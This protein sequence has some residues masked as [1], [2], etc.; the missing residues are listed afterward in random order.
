MNAVK[1]PHA[2]VVHVGNYLKPGCDGAAASLRG[3]VCALHS[4]GVDVSVWQFEVALQQVTSS[5]SDTGL[6]VHRIPRFHNPLLAAVAVPAVSRSWI[7][8]RLSE[9]DFLHLH[10]V[11]TPQNIFS[12]R[13]G[14][15]Y[16]VTPQG[17]WSKHVLRGHRAI[18]KS[19]WIAMFERSLWTNA[20]FVQAV[21]VTECRD[22]RELPRVSR[23]TFIPNGV[24]L[25][26]VFPRDTCRKPYFLFVGRLAVEQKGLD[27]LV[28]AYAAA[29]R[30][31]EHIPDLIIAG[32]DFRDGSVRLRRQISALGLADKIRL[33][34]PVSGETKNSLLRNALVFVH[35]SRWEGMPLSILEALAHATPCIVT[36]P[37]GLGEWVAQNNCGWRV[38]VSVEAIA[39]KL[40]TAA[41]QRSEVEERSLNSRRAVGKDFAW[42]NIASQLNARYQ[43]AIS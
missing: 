38:A 36:E 27:L 21:S 31:Q 22:L 40:V 13:L 3:Q 24:D 19:L 42:K 15:P 6:I 5:I 35:P 29:R 9:A 34:G 41:S 25:P 39:D 18:M 8:C 23:L 43:E 1:P 4:Q 33:S 16:A 14:L 32:P 37:T 28:N 17:G 26:P 2:R 12:A 11:F 30:K 10:S 7:R 20:A